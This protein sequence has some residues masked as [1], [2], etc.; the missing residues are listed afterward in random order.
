MSDVDV[1]A[2][3]EE[4]DGHG[5]AGGEAGSEGESNESDYEKFSFSLPLAF[6]PPMQRPESIALRSRPTS[7]P[8]DLARH[9]STAQGADTV[10]NPLGAFQPRDSAIELRDGSACSVAAS[11]TKITAE[12]I[13]DFYV[14]QVPAGSSGA[15]QGG[16]GKRDKEGVRVNRNGRPDIPRLFADTQLFCQLHGC[17][18]VA[19]VVCG[20]TSMVAAVHAECQQTHRE[21]GMS[22]AVFDLHVEEFCI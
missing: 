13:T 17:D 1:A 6:Q 18:R 9:I 2:A 14:T 20:P 19:V 22:K 16:H 8:M 3:L 12:F 11:S 7:G 5:E 10:V 21:T 4:G 15:A